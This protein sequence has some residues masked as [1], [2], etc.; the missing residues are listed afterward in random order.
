MSK[1]DQRPSPYDIR[2]DI[3]TQL[4]LKREQAIKEVTCYLIDKYLKDVI[5]TKEEKQ[6]FAKQVAKTFDK[7][8]LLVCKHKAYEDFEF[9]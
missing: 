3:R 6:S 1:D 7:Y 9:E 5:L 2:Q 4:S 8:M